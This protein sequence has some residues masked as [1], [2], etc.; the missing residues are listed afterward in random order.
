VGRLGAGQGTRILHE[1]NT[2]PIAID[3]FDTGRF[4]RSLNRFNR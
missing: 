3:K 2:W 4:K 1:P